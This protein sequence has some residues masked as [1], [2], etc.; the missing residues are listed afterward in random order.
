MRRDEI[1]IEWSFAG[2]PAEIRHTTKDGLRPKRCAI[3]CRQ[4]IL[5]TSH[6]EPYK[7]TS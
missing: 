6:L 3:P 1:I 4:A 2:L 7:V 5:D